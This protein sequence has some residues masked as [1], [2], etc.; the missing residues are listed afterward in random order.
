MRTSIEAVLHAAGLS[1]ERVEQV[2]HNALALFLAAA[3]PR[4][5]VVLGKS[6]ADPGRYDAAL[7]FARVCPCVAHEMDPGA[8]EKAG[9][10]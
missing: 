9:A 7:G 6:S 5:C 4:C 3:A 1:L 10:L 8:V 2:E